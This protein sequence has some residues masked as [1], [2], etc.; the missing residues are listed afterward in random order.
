MS[1]M[2]AFASV[3]ASRGWQWLVQ[4]HGMFA[5]ARLYWLM[6]ILGYWMLTIMLSIIPLVGVIAATLLKPVFA[7]GFLAAAWSQER[8][9]P[10]QLSRLFAGFKSNLRAL[11]PLGVVYAVGIGDDANFEGIK[12]SSLRKIAEQTGGRAYFP[13]SNSELQGSFSQIEQELRSQYLVAYSP[14]NKSRDGSYRKVEIEIV[15]PDLR[16]QKLQ[17]NYRQGYFAKRGTAPNIQPPAQ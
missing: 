10:Q 14:S 15:N 4:S 13:R 6:L 12:K 9:E 2:P 17:L 7:V 8:G 16:K 1:T 11:L 3:P 5:Q